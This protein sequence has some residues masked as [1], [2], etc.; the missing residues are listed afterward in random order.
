[1]KIYSLNRKKAIAYFRE[2]LY[3]TNELSNAI[4]LTLQSK[5]GTF[6]SFLPKDVPIEKIHDFSTGGK[7]SSLRLEVA[8]Y[9]TDL[10]NLDVHFNCIFDDFNSS[11]DKIENNDLYESCGVHYVNDVYYLIQSGIDE[12]LITKCLRYSSAIWHSLCVIFK[13]IPHNVNQKMITKDY[14]RQICNNAIFV[15]IE[16]YDSESYVFWKLD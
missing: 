12:K 4:L 10:L 11:L 5:P 13:E 8:K 15:M 14:I 6:F 7:T 3:Q 16:A 1:M 2:N 9:L